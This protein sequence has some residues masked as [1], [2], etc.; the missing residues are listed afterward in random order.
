MALSAE[1]SD[2]FRKC[3]TYINKS[4]NR[5]FQNDCDNRKLTSL[6]GL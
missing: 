5:I 1:L 4:G 3:I 2:K 6:E